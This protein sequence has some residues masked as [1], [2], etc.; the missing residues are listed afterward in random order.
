MSEP[1]NKWLKS[2][3]SSSFNIDQYI[4]DPGLAF[5]SSYDEF[6]SLG[7]KIA[8]TPIHW[9]DI[10]VKWEEAD[11]TWQEFVQLNTGNHLYINLSSNDTSNT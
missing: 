9:E 10:D 6:N 11:F 5:S 3:L 2:K 4:G 8:N 1:T 7:D